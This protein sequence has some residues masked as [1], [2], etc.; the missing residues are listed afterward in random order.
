MNYKYWNTIIITITIESSFNQFG[1]F[2]HLFE[3][4]YFQ[5]N[6]IFF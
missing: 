5:S 1:Y 2:Y 3:F 6:E 4:D